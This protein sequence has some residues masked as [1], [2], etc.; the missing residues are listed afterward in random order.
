MEETTPSEGER[1]E[2]KTGWEPKGSWGGARSGGS[3]SEILF[4]LANHQTDATCP[5]V[6]LPPAAE[7]A[8]GGAGCLVWS[9][10]WP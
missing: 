4:Q 2:R 8:E 6:H 5:G 1:E 9:P 7:S 3:S 10:E